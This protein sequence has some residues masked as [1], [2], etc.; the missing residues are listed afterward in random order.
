M[1]IF[2]S[3]QTA[4]KALEKYFGRSRIVNKY[5]RELEALANHNLV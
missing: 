2:F 4:Q 5:R 3:D 1:P